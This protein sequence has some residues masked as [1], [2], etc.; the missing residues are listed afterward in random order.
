MAKEEGKNEPTD[1]HLTKG[2][3]LQFPLFLFLID[4]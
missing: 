3:C 2:M 4:H 1:R